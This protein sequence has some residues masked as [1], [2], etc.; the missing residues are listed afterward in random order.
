MHAI[1]M[2]I[3]QLANRSMG[4]SNMG[5]SSGVNNRQ[6]M[7][8]QRGGFGGCRRGRRSSGSADDPGSVR[9]SDEPGSAGFAGDQHA[10]QQPGK[11]HHGSRPGERACPAG[12][13]RAEHRPV[14]S[15]RG[16]EAIDSGRHIANCESMEHLISK[17]FMNSSFAI[18]NP[19]SDSFTSSEGDLGSQ[20]R[21]VAGPALTYSSPA[22]SDLE[23]KRPLSATSI[24]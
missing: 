7:G 4:Y 11:L 16:S 24:M 15:L 23:I 9:Q 17:A 10:A 20:V 18:W 6:A 1:S 22:S 8:M 12:H 14:D 5:F 21:R 19:L 2:A 3:R 13:P